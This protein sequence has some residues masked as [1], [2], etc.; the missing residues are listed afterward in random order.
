MISKRP[1][2]S[3]LLVF[4]EADISSQLE[5]IAKQ[6]LRSFD[7]VSVIYLGRQESLLW[8]N[9][10]G[11]DAQLILIEKSR[12]K[13]D[14]LRLLKTVFQVNHQKKL[15]TVFSSGLMSNLAASLI[16]YVF[17]IE[18]RISLRHH[19]Y[20]HQLRKNTKGI[21]YDRI[22]TSLSTKIIAVSN[23]AKDAILEIDSVKPEKVITIYNGFDTSKFIGL[24]DE[25]EEF[26][27]TQRSFRIG[28][29]SRQTHSKGI[30]YVI[31]AFQKFN[32]KIIDSEL[33]L[34]GADSDATE[35]INKV[36]LNLDPT[37]FIRIKYSDNIE[38]ELSKIDV[39]VHVPIGINEESFGLVYLETLAAGKKCIFTCS[40]IMYE[41]SRLQKYTKIV[42]FCDAKGIE[43]ALFEFHQNRKIKSEVAPVEI[44]NEYSLEVMGDKYL[45]LFNSL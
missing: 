14:F 23:S 6:A 42:K 33:V 25:T 27:E 43:V 39:M 19:S 36:L 3:A 21:I 35:K 29:I 30:E 7:T 5:E 11:I 31:E 4:S 13:Y 9:L 22:I 10:K 37:K 2:L 34:I 16:S 8:Q 17:K 12:K 24:R 41:D 1:G 15:H 20:Y 18:N 26:G 45:E 40:G 28:C 38:M 32:S 44:I